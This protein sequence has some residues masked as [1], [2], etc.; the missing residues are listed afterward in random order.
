[1]AIAAVALPSIRK[2]E[3]HRTVS[4][5]F[6]LCLW[7]SDNFS[8][9]PDVLGRSQPHAAD[10]AAVCLADLKRLRSRFRELRDGIRETFFV[11]DE[12][13]VISSARLLLK[14]C[15]VF[16][17][18][19]T[20]DFAILFS[21]ARLLLSEASR[22]QRNYIRE[23][24]LEALRSLADLVMWNSRLWSEVL[25]AEAE[26]VSLY[27]RP[28]E[29]PTFTVVRQEAAKSKPKAKTRA[30]VDA[31]QAP[32]PRDHRRSPNSRRRT[33]ICGQSG[34][35]SSTRSSNRLQQLREE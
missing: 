5:T 8:Q 12:Q 16:L 27:P 31:S 17:G 30:S 15:K 21:T 9:A 29:V 18:S 26:L 3:L 35:P 14:P 34:M 13:Q 25:S 20:R 22:L 4:R 19:L 10:Q 28:M 1:M 32:P 2:L 23:L 7:R 6:R 24:I 11:S 33:K